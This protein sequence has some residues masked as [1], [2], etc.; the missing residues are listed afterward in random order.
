MEF[1]TDNASNMITTGCIFRTKLF[2]EF[3]NNDI[4]HFRYAA[5]ILNLGVKEGIKLVDTKNS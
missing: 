2:E 5:H 3:E 1:L 4:D